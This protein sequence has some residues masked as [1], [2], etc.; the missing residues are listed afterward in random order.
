[1]L[2]SA[3]LSVIRIEGSFSKSQSTST[4]SRSNSSLVGAETSVDRGAE[5]S[6]SGEEVDVDA[7]RW[8]G[9]AVP[10]LEWAVRGEVECHAG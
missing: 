4:S 8:V 3:A 9:A 7:K 6:G 1:M 10:I 2:T 5:S